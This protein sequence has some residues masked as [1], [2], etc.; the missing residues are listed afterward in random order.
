[1]EAVEPVDGSLRR[2]FPPHKTL[3]G[4]RLHARTLSNRQTEAKIGCSVINRMTRL[5]MP[6]SVRVR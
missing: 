3:I 5:G 4:R 2:Q 1:M 6:V